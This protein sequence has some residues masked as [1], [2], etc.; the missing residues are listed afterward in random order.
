MTQ[1]TKK[2]PFREEA[3][4]HA[5]TSRKEGTILML[6]P[7][8][9][10]W[11]YWV[12]VAV[13]AVGALF[14]IFGSVNEYAIG[15][16]IVR[17]RSRVDVTAAVAGVVGAIAVSA[18]QRV[19]AHSV[20]AR[21]N[22]ASEMAQVD[23]LQHEFEL[24]LI[25]ALRS[26]ADKQMRDSLASVRVQKELAEAH[27][28]QLTIRAPRAGLVGDVRIRPGQRLDVGDLVI[29]LADE[30]APMSVIAMLPGQFRPQLRAGMPLRF[31][32]SGYLYAYQE[33]VIESV[34]KQVIGPDEVKRYLGQEIFDTVKVDGPV[35]LVEA[36]CPEPT[37]RVDNQT[38]DYHHGMSGRADARVRS[39]SILVALIPGLR[40]VFERFGG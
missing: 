30:S 5:A 29:T 37:F 20:V 39:E 22:S 33:F 38:Y 19:E 18:G 32:V 34:S 21:L 6:S 9:T 26:P 12:L 14:A 1:A 31:E 40:V 13:A 27:L 16:A 3:L 2:S 10:R 4:R 7:G 28:E 11:T 17:V 35:V 23:R 8:W 25:G 15:P 24:Q 36:K